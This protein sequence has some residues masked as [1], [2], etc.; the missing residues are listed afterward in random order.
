MRVLYTAK[1]LNRSS[2]V[3][4][5]ILPVCSTIALADDACRDVYLNSVR[6]IDT[7]VRN[8]QEYDYIFD[9]ACE[10]N[11][12]FRKT[13][14]NKKLGI[15][16]EDLPLDYTAGETTNEGKMSSFCKSYSSV[17]NVLNR[18]VSYKNDVQIAALQQFN[19]C[20]DFL[21]RGISFSSSQIGLSAGTINAT[22][23]NRTTDLYINSV[24]YDPTLLQCKVSSEDLQPAPDLTLKDAF[25]VNKN[26]TVTCDRIVQIDKDRPFFPPADLRLETN[27]GGYSAHFEGDALNGFYYATEAKQKFDAANSERDIAAKSLATLLDHVMKANVRVFRFYNGDPG[28]DGGLSG[29]RLNCGDVNARAA[30]I[31][32][33]SKYFLSGVPGMTGMSGGR[34]GYDYYNVACLDLDISH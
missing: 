9:T 27:E 34:C 8:Y 4:F 30:S 32:G 22:F 5:L 20:E 12:S 31:C 26:F 14:D 10:K 23:K 19:E 24:V 6:N 2:L 17:I 28:G 33:G 13:S 15:M 11:G 16:V 7:E 21:T 29:P 3:T 1:F 18:Y 25:Q